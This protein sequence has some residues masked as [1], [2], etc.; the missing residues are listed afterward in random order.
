MIV[1]LPIIYRSIKKH[2]ALSVKKFI[3]RVCP[4]ATVKSENPWMHV[5]VF[6]SEHEIFRTSKMFLDNFWYTV[7]LIGARGGYHES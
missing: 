1:L 2:L 6:L 4:V 3:F 7:I 5:E